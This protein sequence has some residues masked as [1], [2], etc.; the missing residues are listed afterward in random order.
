M[1]IQYCSDLHLEFP[2]NKEFIKDC[3][4]EPN[5]EILILAGDVIPFA[6]MDKHKDFF[7]YCSDN[8]D[9]TYWLPGNHEYYHFDLAKKCGV[10]NESI[11]KNVFLVNDLA[12]DIQQTRFLFSTLWSK[13]NV[14]NEWT[15]ENSLN[16]FRLIKY[17]GF[18]FTTQQYNQLYAA[19]FDFIKANLSTEKF[20]KT[21]VVTHHVPTLKNYP[22]QYINSNINEAFAVELHDFIETS[23]IDYWIYGHHHT[24]TVDFTIGKTNLLTNQLGYVRHGE[25]RNYKNGKIFEV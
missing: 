21:V 17:D 12:I 22:A 4:I 6:L 10:L 1:I 2:E 25:H 8:F 24:N 9:K 7:K 23:N 19:S 14:V 3:P 11:R 13:I 18:R 15:I 16:D 5:G 20:D